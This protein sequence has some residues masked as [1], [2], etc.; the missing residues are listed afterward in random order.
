ML[1]TNGRTPEPVDLRVQGGRVVAC[2]PRIEAGK[3]EPVVDLG[4]RMI[5]HGLRD[6]HVHFAQW[7]RSRVEL[8]LSG[9]RSVDEA[10]RRVAHAAVDL[11]PGAVLRGGG[12]RDALWLEQPTKQVLD[13]AAP[14]CLVVLNSLDMHTVWLSSRALD[15]AGRPEHPTG[16]LKEHEAWQ[17]ITRLPPPTEAEEDVAADAAVTAAH[18]RGVTTVRDFDFA[19]AYATWRRRQQSS[20]MRLRVTAIVMPEQLPSYAAARLRTGDGQ[21]LLRLGPLK[22][23]VDGS[24]GS[25][26][27]RCLRPYAGTTDRGQLLLDADSLRRALHGARDAGFAVAVH[28]IGDEAN[29]IALQTLAEVGVPASVEHAQLLRRE[30]LPGFRQAGVVASLQPAHLLD[31]HAL[32]DHH[33]QGTPSLP[34]ALRSLV[35]TG[36]R[37]VFGSD[38][39]VSALDPWRSIAAAVHRTE[40]AL[41]PWQP[42]EA[43]D[44]ETALAASG[45]RRVRAGDDADLVVLDVPH[46]DGAAAH[47]LLTTPVHATCVA[48]RW[49][50]GPWREV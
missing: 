45:A 18:A 38:A 10:A 29:G 2:A 47:E 8:D 40:G 33:W 19:D 49:V 1:L 50:R 31:D 37:V 7:A 42:D 39:P 34:F 43:V 3:G 30:D 15:A 27:A 35:E 13:Q 25:R 12:F 26:T 5:R 11:A 6:A 21:D 28:A 20:G 46:L 4:G 9:T 24:L 16:L 44:V 32:V 22:L 17:A 23:F 36:A 41:D 14:G 48:G